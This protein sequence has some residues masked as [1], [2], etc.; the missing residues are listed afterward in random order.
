MRA[1]E[2]GRIVTRRYWDVWDH[3]T[4]AT[5]E[6]E[7]QIAERVLDALRTSVR[8]RKVSDVPVG[9]FLSGGIDSSTN[10][11]LFSEGEDRPVRTFSIGYQGE[12]QT[13]T[14]EFVYARMMAKEIGAEHHE[15]ALTQEDLL[16][17]LPQMVRLQDE[18]IA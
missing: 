5:S 15:R 16:S 17:F 14:N 7:D 9:V 2:H 13:Y 12:Y 10:A 3:V 1:D 11:A 18:P 8:L 6:S 4:P